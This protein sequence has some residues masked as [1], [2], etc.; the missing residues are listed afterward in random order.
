[1]SPSPRLKTETDTFSESLFFLDLGY[2]LS[3]SLINFNLSKE[4]N[5]VGVLLISPEDGNRSSFLKVV[6]SDCLEFQMINKVHKPSDPKLLCLSYNYFS[7][8]TVF[9]TPFLVKKTEIMAVGDQSHDTPTSG[10]IP[11]RTKA[12]ELVYQ[13]IHLDPH[14]KMNICIDPDTFLLLILILCSKL[15]LSF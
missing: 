5:R 11:S 6:L 9:I 3:I 14:S 2:L 1:V 8:V 10:N 4:S 7:L 13:T 15:G 12:M